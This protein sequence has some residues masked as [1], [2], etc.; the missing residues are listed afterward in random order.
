MKFVRVFVVVA[1]IA[2]LAAPVAARADDAAGDAVIDVQTPPSFVGYTLAGSLA[3]AFG[4]QCTTTLTAPSGVQVGD[5]LI[6]NVQADANLKK[7]YPAP[8][9]LPPGWVVLPFKNK[10]QSTM[11]LSRNLLGIAYS[12]YLLAYVYG[13]QPDDSGQYQIGFS[14]VSVNS[15]S[16]EGFLVAYRGASIN[17]SSYLA[18]A[19][20]TNSTNSFARANQIKVSILNSTLLTLFDGNPYFAKLTRECVLYGPIS[21]NPPLTLET[22]RNPCADDPSDR[23]L[24]AADVPVLKAKKLFGA[25]TSLINGGNAGDGGINYSFQV[26]IPPISP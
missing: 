11:S 1:L 25:Y 23:E 3:C 10:Q 14:N 4:A 20:P 16:I 5:V 12:D 13:S 17:L 21:G 19:Y 22:P 24:L 7:S 26:V 18:Y 15:M 9:V 2:V 6:A 8:D